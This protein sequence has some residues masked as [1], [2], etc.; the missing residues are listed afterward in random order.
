MVD[1]SDICFNEN[2]ESGGDT[3]IKFKNKDKELY[4]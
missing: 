1:T 4:D 2:W 3:Q